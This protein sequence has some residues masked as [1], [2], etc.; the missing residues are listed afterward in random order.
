M[1]QGGWI[2]L[3]ADCN[4]AQAFESHETDNVRVTL[5]FSFR[6]HL[7]SSRMG[8]RSPLPGRNGLRQTGS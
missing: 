7:T 4:M 3:E 2:K 8:F 6:R 1:G 5:R